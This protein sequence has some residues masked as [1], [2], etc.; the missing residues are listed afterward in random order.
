MRGID[1]LIQR[2]DVN[3]ARLGAFGCSGREN[4][5]AYLV[6]LEP[7]IAVTATA[8]YITSFDELLT[9]TGA[10]DAEQTLPNFVA[11]GLDLADWVDLC[12]PKPYAIIVR[13]QSY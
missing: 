4:I 5:T 3:G 11:A 13:G 8:C 2:K 6:A 9:S 10:P 1:Y 12:A 7:G